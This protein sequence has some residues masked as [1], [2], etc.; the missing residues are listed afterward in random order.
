MLDY[1]KNVLLLR[2]FSRSVN[3]F[4]SFKKFYNWCILLLSLA[5]WLIK[6]SKGHVKQ[7]MFEDVPQINGSI[8]ENMVI[9]SATECTIR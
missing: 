5:C 1:F 7:S 9:T 3:T 8:G 4:K 2:C 6:C